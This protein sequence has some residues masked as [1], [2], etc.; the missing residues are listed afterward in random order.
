MSQTYQTSDIKLVA[1][2]LYC[3]FNYENVYLVDE[4]KAIFVFD[5]TNKLDKEVSKFLSGKGLV[6]PVK[7]INNIN[8]C[9]SDIYNLKKQQVKR[10]LSQNLRW[11]N[12]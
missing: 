6:E 1:Y 12:Y 7:Y 9:K 2:L 4:K 3:D 5:K 10:N 8:L 11:Q